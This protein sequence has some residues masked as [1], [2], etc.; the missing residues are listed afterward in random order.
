MSLEIQGIPFI[1]EANPN[2]LFTE[3]EKGYDINLLLVLAILVL[4]TN[5]KGTGALDRV[6][7]K[8]EEATRT[9]E[10]LRGLQNNL[11]T[12]NEKIGKFQLSAEKE[13]TAH[14]WEEDKVGNIIKEFANGILEL[15]KNITELEKRVK[16]YPDLETLLAT[17]QDLFKCFSKNFNPIDNRSMIDAI[18]DWKEDQDL[19]FHGTDL[20]FQPNDQKKDPTQFNRMIAWAMTQVYLIN[21]GKIK[22]P[23]AENPLE[24]WNADGNASE[25]MLIGQSQ[26]SSIEM[27]SY[28]TLIT[29]YNNTMKSSLQACKKELQKM[30]REQISQ[31]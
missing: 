24:D 2:N 27:K 26:Q 21:E 9:A 18:S 28:M 12:I 30:V 3:K 17:T 15:Q 14:T 8:M 16:K 13:P 29:S 7:K 23:K 10:E 1:E 4:V 11:I 22:D 5:P 6:A 25:Q 31:N 20:Y 19:N